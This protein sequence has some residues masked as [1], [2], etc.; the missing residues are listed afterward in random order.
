MRYSGLIIG[1]V[2]GNLLVIS[3]CAVPHNDVM[4][5]GTDSQIA[6]DVSANPEQANVPHLTI[7]WKR[8]EF[9]WMPLFANGEHSVVA[10]Y[11][12]DRNTLAT[13]DGVKII[14]PPGEGITVQPGKAQKVPDGTKI[15]ISDS[16]E[17]IFTKGTQ[18]LIPGNNPLTIDKGGTAMLPAGSE[19]SLAQGSVLVPPGMGQ[20]VDVSAAKYVGEKP[21]PERDTYSVIATFGSDIKASG[22]AAGV[23]I[24]QYFATGIAA[25][26]LAEQGG[27]R[28]VSIQP[29]ESVSQEI[30]EAA[31]KQLAR[32]YTDIERIL[33][34]V[35]KDGNVD[36]ERLTQLT[37]GTGLLETDPKWVSKF[38]GKPVGDLRKELDGPSRRAVPRLAANIKEGGS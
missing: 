20:G 9:V 36:E 19:I 25:R 24:A 6:V 2:L 16:T 32:E 14:A 29:E 13:P 35:N 1:I 8:R 4:L 3:G 26:R 11:L 5:F 17:I 23:G 12:R 27:A 34:Y 7:G 18:V 37:P 31:R 22:T 38:K 33:T 10:R 28:L 30:K 15:T 21:G